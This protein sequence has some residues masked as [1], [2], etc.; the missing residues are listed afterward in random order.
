LGLKVNHLDIPPYVG[1]G[2]GMINDREK[3]HWVGRPTPIQF[4]VLVG[5]RSLAL[6][7][8]LAPLVDH[9]CVASQK[10]AIDGVG[11]IDVATTRISDDCVGQ[12]LMS[13]HA[14]P[15]VLEYLPHKMIEL[16]LVQ[17]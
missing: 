3:Y 9:V 8:T 13:R 17:Q 4:R 15:R 14:Q 6:T 10:E 16:I 2:Q 1:H 12:Y 5:E 11:D 7:P